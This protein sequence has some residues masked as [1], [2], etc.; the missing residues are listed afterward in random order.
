MGLLNHGPELACQV[1]RKSGLLPIHAR[2]DGFTAAWDLMQLYTTTDGCGEHT[3]QSSG[4]DNVINVDRKGD[5]DSTC[6]SG[7][8]VTWASPLVYMLGA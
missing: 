5:M 6:P 8:S 1:D 4:G 3:Q 2:L 7:A